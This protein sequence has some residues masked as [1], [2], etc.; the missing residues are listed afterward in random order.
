ML[1]WMNQDAS[2]HQRR[3]PPTAHELGGIP[4]LG[5]LQPAERER[6]VAALVVGD[7]RPGD[8]V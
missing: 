1:A 4:W 3:R 8:Y 7:A 5:L 6:A 2:L